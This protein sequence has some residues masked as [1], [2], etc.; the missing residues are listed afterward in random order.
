MCS[1]FN[2]AW[3]IIRRTILFP[4]YIAM[5]ING[6][7]VFKGYVFVIAPWGYNG[8]KTWQYSENKW[9]HAICWAPIV[10][11]FGFRG[12]QRNWWAT[13]SERHG[14]RTL[15]LV[16]LLHVEYMIGNIEMAYS[17]SMRSI[18]QSTSLHVNGWGRW[19]RRWTEHQTDNAADTARNMTCA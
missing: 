7:R 19:R 5:P 2:M 14:V 18:Y 12:S 9:T 6:H 16:F 10:E 1:L 15:T 13:D 4:F 8:T 11:R 3:N 17:N